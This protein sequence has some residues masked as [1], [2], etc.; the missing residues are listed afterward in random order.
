MNKNQNY[1]QGK[2]FSGKL[3]IQEYLQNETD[4]PILEN[5]SMTNKILTAKVSDSV[6]ITLCTELWR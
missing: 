4:E 3:N 1:N 2:K 5:Y 6:G